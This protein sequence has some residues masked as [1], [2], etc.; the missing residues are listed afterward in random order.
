MSSNNASRSKKYKKRK[1]N[2]KR[3]LAFLPSSSSDSDEEELPHSQRGQK[4]TQVKGLAPEIKKAISTSTARGDAA[5]KKMEQRHFE[6][7][8]AKDEKELEQQVKVASKEESSV[9]HDVGEKRFELR[10]PGVDQSAVLEYDIEGE[11]QTSGDFLSS[12]T[13]RINFWH[14]LIPDKLKNLGTGDRLANAALDYAMERQ[15]KIRLTHPFLRKWIELNGTASQKALVVSGAPKPA[16]GN[17]EPSRPEK[18]KPMFPVYNR[19]HG[20]FMN[21]YELPK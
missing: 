9:F 20:N 3:G 19:S 17:E 8:E 14:A 10:F 21:E 5:V 2:E 12:R 15:M 11:D 7:L 13:T 6:R 1:M 18:P 4:Q 16:P